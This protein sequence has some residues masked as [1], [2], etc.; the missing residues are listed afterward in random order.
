VADFPSPTLHGSSSRGNLSPQGAFKTF[1]S[2]LP[3]SVESFAEGTLFTNGFPSFSSSVV[4]SY[5]AFFFPVPWLPPMS[6][7][8]IVFALFRL[9]P[10]PYV[11]PLG[12]KIYIMSFDKKRPHQAPF[13]PKMKCTFDFSSPSF[14]SR[15][16][17]P[18]SPLRSF[19]FYSPDSRIPGYD[20][21]P[22]C[23]CTFPFGY[24]SLFSLIFPAIPVSPHSL[25]GHP[26]R[27]P[28]FISFSAHPYKDFDSRHFTKTHLPLSSPP[29]Q[30]P[31]H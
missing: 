17:L 29:P 20:P 12:P 30:F 31:I 7:S 28:S 24:D 11:L 3:K 19:P 27:Y 26:L 1:A 10:S 5:S 18:T 9:F 8:P 15:A 2:P 21:T 22:N 4:W 23:M 16:P 13:V 6:L 25:L 14:T